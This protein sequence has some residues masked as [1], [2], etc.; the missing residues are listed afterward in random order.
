[1]VLLV[2]RIGNDVGLSRALI[3]PARIKMKHVSFCLMLTSPTMKS[4]ELG[5]EE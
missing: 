4:E 2:K 5:K 1:M 3:G